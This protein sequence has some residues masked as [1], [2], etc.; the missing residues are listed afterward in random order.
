MYLILVAEN[1]K[2]E[3]VSKQKCIT[4]YNR[5]N[6]YERFNQLEKNHQKLNRMNRFDKTKL[7]KIIQI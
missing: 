5:V 2:K 7:Q 1:G 3:G 6:N 4:I